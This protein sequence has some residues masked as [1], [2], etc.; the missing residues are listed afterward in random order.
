MGK[1]FRERNTHHSPK[2]PRWDREPGTNSPESKDLLK[3]RA[4]E[5]KNPRHAG[6]EHLLSR[7]VKCRQCGLSYTYSP[8]CKKGGIY[9]YL[10]CDRRKNEGIKGCDSPWLRVEWFETLV[11]DK[12]LSDILV[13]N[14]IDPAIQALGAE[15]E[16]LVTKAQKNLADIEK[17]LHDIEKRQDRIFLAFE[18]GEVDLE[19]YGRRNRELEESKGLIMTEYQNAMAS[20]GQGRNHPRKSGCCDGLH[21]GIERVPAFQREGKVQALA[22]ELY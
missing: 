16:G 5:V 14:T 7:M 6:S 1:E 4:P 11:M 3:S 9:K 15:S 10:V 13:P 8:S 21:P 22:G 12:T 18:N 2:L 20:L 19:R 17:R